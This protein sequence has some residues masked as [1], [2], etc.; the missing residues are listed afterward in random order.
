MKVT[1][2]SKDVGDTKVKK[3]KFPNI[4][5]SLEDYN[6]IYIKRELGIK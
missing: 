2:K 5:F 1:I 6:E 4:K 3:C